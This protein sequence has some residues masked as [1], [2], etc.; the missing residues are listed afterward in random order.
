MNRAIALVCVGAASLAATG[1]GFQL[2]GGALSEDID[3]YQIN[4]P[5]SS[6]VA[7]RLELQLEDFGMRAGGEKQIGFQIARESFTAGRSLASKA[8]TTAEIELSLSVEALITLPGEEPFKVEYKLHDFY[9]I[10][11][12]DPH[13]NRALRRKLEDYLAGEAAILLIESVANQT[14]RTRH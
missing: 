1:C 5:S 2:V 6:K 13:A 3:G 14:Y 7:K 4:A 9:P 8:A 12:S 11:Y 10:N